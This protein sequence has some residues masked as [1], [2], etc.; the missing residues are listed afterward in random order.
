MKII[1]AR[2]AE[3]K[4]MRKHAQANPLRH[5]K[6]R[7]QQFSSLMFSSVIPSLII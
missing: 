1:V 2:I 7:Q 6:V 3:K 5:H 4:I